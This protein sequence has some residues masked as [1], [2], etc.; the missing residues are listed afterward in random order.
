MP[1]FSQP[2]RDG[3]LPEGVPEWREALGS[4]MPRGL[5]YTGR[6]AQ[7][8]VPCDR[9]YRIAA[10]FK[11]K[12]AK[13]GLF[14]Y[15]D[16][17]QRAARLAGDRAAEMCCGHG[18]PL[19]ARILRHTWRSIPGAEFDF[20]MALVTAELG[21]PRVDQA[22]GEPEPTAD[23]LLAPGGTSPEEYS[24]LAGEPAHEFYNE[25]DVAE[26]SGAHLEPVSFSYGEHVESCAAIDYAPFVER[27]EKRARFHYK[28]LTSLSGAERLPFAILRREWWAVPDTLVVV[29]VYFQA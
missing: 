1:D 18:E 23:A 7:D 27:A 28:V 8:V 16:I 21:C 22:E 25:Y 15:A 10:V 29:V 19:R 9:Q 13:G 2:G 17:Y 6:N 24:R 5:I 20:P 14:D 26:R 4:L 3:A 11:Q 12:V